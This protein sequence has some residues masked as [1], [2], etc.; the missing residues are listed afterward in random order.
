MNKRKKILGGKRNYEQR[1]NE[2]HIK[3]IQRR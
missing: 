3:I 1:R 2:E